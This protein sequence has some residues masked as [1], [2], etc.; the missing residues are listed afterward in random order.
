VFLIFANQSFLTEA[1]EQA[2]NERESNTDKIDKLFELKYTTFTFIQ[3]VVICKIPVQFN[4][5]TH[6]TRQSSCLR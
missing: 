2:V 6:A 1:I 3:A 5:P 4:C